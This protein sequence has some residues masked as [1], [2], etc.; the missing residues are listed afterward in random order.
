MTPEQLFGLTGR[1]ALVTGGATGIGAMITE[2]LIAAG[3]DVMISSRKGDACIEAAKSFNAMN[4]AGK[5][6]G[7]AGDVSSEDSIARLVEDV[8]ARTDSLDILVNNAGLTWGEKLGDFPHHAWQRV[9][10]VNVAGLFQLTQSLLPLLEKAS[11]N[12]S[13]ARVIN[14][15]SVMGDQPMGDGAYSYAASKAANHHL[16]QILGKELTSRR[17]TVNAIAPGPFVS[18]MTAFAT[19]DEDRRQKVGEGVPLGRV[20]VKEDIA[21]CLQFLCGQG[22]AYITGAILPVSGGL[23]VGSAPSLFERAFT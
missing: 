2:G 17:I 19:A 4:Y 3:A 7:F 5:V 14:V 10:N 23:N 1:K 6:E 16:T 12:D 20:G 11:S 21:G 15:G 9:M 18:N 13:P 8:S 22:G